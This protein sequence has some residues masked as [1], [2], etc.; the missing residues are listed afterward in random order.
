MSNK[1]QEALNNIKEKTTEIE[2]YASIPKAAY[3]CTDEELQVLQKL[4]DK[5]TPKKVLY[6]KA[7]APSL[8]YMYSCPSCGTMQSVNCKSFFKYC[9]ECGQA[10]DWSVEDGK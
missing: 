8:A 3:C 9:N 4:V 1:Y 7:P 6:V 5:A 10:L 2:D